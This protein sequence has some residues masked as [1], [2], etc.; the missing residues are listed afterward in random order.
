MPLTKWQPPAAR[1]SVDDDGRV[2]WLE[3]F[4]DLVFVA[5]LIQLGDRLADDV[6][7]RGGIVFSGAFV[8]LWWT[9]TGTTAFNNRFAVDDIVHR[10]LT[11]AQMI[12]VGNLATIAAAAPD[13][14]R[15]WLPLAYIAARVPM[16]IMYARARRR[17]PEALDTVNL[18]LGVFGAGALI[19]LL[20]LAVPP[21]VR[22]ALWLLALLIE[23]AAPAIGAR[24]GYGPPMHLEHFEERYAL[25]TI[26]VLGETF[27]K[28]LTKATEIAGETGI[29]GVT[30]VF[31]GLAFAILVAIWWTYFDDVAGGHVRRVS[32]LTSWPPGNRL[33]WTYTHL[34][35]AIG[36]TAFGVAA[37]KVVGA[38]EF[39]E[40]FKDTYTWLLVIALITVLLSVAVLDLV[41]ASPHY[42]V[43]TQTRVGPRLVAAV[44]L[45]PIGFLVA[46]GALNALV[47]VGIVALVVVLQIA[48]EVVQ[49][50]KTERRLNRQV[51]ADI[52]DQTGDCQ[53]LQTAAPPGPIPPLECAP[54]RAK[55]VDWV[56]LRWC[57]T[58]GEVGCCDDGEGRHARAHFE[59]TGHP[60]IATIEPGGNWA[61]CYLHDHSSVDW[62]SD[63]RESTTG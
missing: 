52:E 12:A 59:Q 47:G 56:Q 5:A 63:H 23:F 11:F 9:W 57:L 30:F 62:W 61:Y 55:G 13:D 58:C 33:I 3:L 21:G 34:P 15:T 48:A 10:L 20:S 31:G 49:A 25:F 42:S 19:W 17:V 1:H 29:S 36:I 7:W 18:F 44:A 16:L 53:P 35:L 24:K 37:K 32:A 45:V 6:S 51:Q 40:A 41:T 27:V 50:Q 28:T 26:I 4:F 60:V 2:T 54:C 14:W 46:S 22:P 39:T 43:D 38:K 8:L